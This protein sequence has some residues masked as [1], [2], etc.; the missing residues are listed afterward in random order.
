MPPS[1]FWA[2]AATLRF[3]A[4][5]YAYL[6]MV[7]GKY[8][9]ELFGD[10]TYTVRIDAPS[11]PEGPSY[12]LVPQPHYGAPPPPRQGAGPTPTQYAPPPYPT[13]V[14]GVPAGYSAPAGYGAP[15][16]PSV[17]VPAPD[18]A[19]PGG[20][21][22][23]Q[24]PPPMYFGPQPA[25]A[26]YGDPAGAPPAYPPSAA[27]PYPQSAGAPPYPGV[28]P[29]PGVFAGAP[30]T[31][32]VVLTQASK[33]ILVL[34]LV[35]GGFGTALNYAFAIPTFLGVSANVAAQ[36]AASD[37]LAAHDQLSATLDS[38]EQK[39]AGCAQSLSCV[40]SGD[41]ELA[42]AFA[43]Y[44]ARQAQISFPAG[45]QAA[46]AQVAQAAATLV[47]LLRQLSTDSPSAYVSDAS[48]LQT[49]ANNFDSSFQALANTLPFT[50]GALPAR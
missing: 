2:M 23:H 4:R 44:Q 9:G 45:S 49:A 27:P 33:G 3:Q 30:R 47:A 15:A 13:D 41:A 17:D 43:T 1:L 19:D 29:H 10:A 40:Q 7:T 6:F 32:P 5:A 35:L 25:P 28:A 8:P 14:P 50:T 24:P 26:V 42:S 22:P 46:A 12:G 21:E 16:G 20:Q 18:P 39:Q 36:H 31:G 34:F 48:R 38:I 37:I 11:V